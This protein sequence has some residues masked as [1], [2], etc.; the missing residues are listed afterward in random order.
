MDK[1][2]FDNPQ[3]IL[4]NLSLRQK[5]AQLC[6]VAAVSNE[7]K[8]EEF[9]KRWQQWQPL[10]CLKTS[11][12]AKMLVEEHNVGGV[13]FYGLKTLPEEQQSLTKE[14]QE[15]SPIPLFIA[16]DAENGLVACSKRVPLFNIRVMW[17]SEL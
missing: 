3:I 14:L 12:Y 13:I 4:S 10:Y 16:M 5:I 7:A 17:P 2:S 11:G 6:I 15:T 9:L 8:N 1:T